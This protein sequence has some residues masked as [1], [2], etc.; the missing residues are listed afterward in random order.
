M[1]VNGFRLPAAFVQ[2]CEAIRREEMPAEW[3][4]KDSV[5]A[6]GHPWEVDDLRIISDQE[7]IQS[8]TERLS[9]SFLHD[10]RSVQFPAG[11]Y[12]DGPGFM[13]DFTG[14]SKFV[15]FGSSTTG[16]TYAF[17]FGTDANDPSVAYYG[18]E[19]WRRVAPNFSAFM[20][21][22]IDADEVELEG[23]DEPPRRDSPRDL[24]AAWVSLY[25]LTINEGA[26]PS[27]ESMAYYYDQCSVEERREVEEQVRKELETQGM[28]DE[29]RRTLEEVWARLRSSLPS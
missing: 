9:K 14:V 15:M 6:S 29:Q 4:L 19:Y 28:T 23:D 24:V 11:D 18:E 25:V 1:V 22:F 7:T 13:A 26:R 17:D 12:A 16:E 3:A 8:M 21:L 20:A 10:D 5:D 2:L 27:I